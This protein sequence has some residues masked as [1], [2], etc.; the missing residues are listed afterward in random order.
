MNSPCNEAVE[1][2]ICD[3]EAVDELKNTRDHEKDTE[4]VDEL[5]A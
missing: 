2:E 1:G 5:Q 3:G 4:G